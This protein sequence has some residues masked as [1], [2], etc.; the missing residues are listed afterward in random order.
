MKPSKLLT[1]HEIVA[2]LGEVELQRVISTQRDAEPARQELRQRVAVVV[3]E[4]RVVAQRG[5]GDGDLSQV[6]QVLEDWHLQ[7]YNNISN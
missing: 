2:N 1:T 6:V 5:H 7:E 3:Q 4:Q